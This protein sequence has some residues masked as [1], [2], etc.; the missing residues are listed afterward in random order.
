M[1]SIQLFQFP[2]EKAYHLLI[3]GAKY[4][5]ITFNFRGKNLWEKSRRPETFVDV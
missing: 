1:I 4:A 3:I 2:K 5:I